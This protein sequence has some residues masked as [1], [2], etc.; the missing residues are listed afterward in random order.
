MHSFIHLLLRWLNGIT[1]EQWKAALDVVLSLADSEL[2]GEAKRQAAVG[3]LLDV[4][5][6]S[7]A[8]FLIELALQ[9]AKKKNWL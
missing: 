5:K 8:N 4:V 1:A 6:G 2:T 7:K 3:A 9:F